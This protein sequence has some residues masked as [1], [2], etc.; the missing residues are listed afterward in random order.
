[1]KAGTSAHWV[2]DTRTTICL[3]GAHGQVNKEQVFRAEQTAT[4]EGRHTDTETV[5]H[6]EGLKIEPDNM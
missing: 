2:T 4:V 3:R 6:M 1:M 5:T